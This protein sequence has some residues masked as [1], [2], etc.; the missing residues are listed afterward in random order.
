MNTA[1]HP[2]AASSQPTNPDLEDNEVVA[3]RSP[4]DELLEQLGR[5]QEEMRTQEL[6]DVLGADSGMAA[7]HD[8]I[9]AEQ[10][11][12]N[13]A[14]IAAGEL[15]AP[16][17]DEVLTDGAASVEPMYEPES[18]PVP[19]PLPEQ[20]QNDPLAEYIRM[21][22]GQP[23]F[24][25]KV[26]GQ[27]MLI[28]LEQARRQI[29]IGTAAEIRMQEAATL[30]AQV[31]ERERQ[32]AASE[33]ALA[34]RKEAALAAPIVPETPDLSEEDLLTEAKEIF[35][36]AFTGTE[37][38]AAQKLAKVLIKLKTPAMPAAQPID[39]D[40]IARKA[41]AAAAQVLEGRDKQKDVQ[42][43]YAQFKTDYP[44]IMAD[45][46]LYRM[47]DDMTD[48]I[49]REHPEWDISQVMLEAGKRT[50]AWVNNLKGDE[51]TQ[52]PKS[53][54]KDKVTDSQPQIPPIDRQARKQ[55]LVRIPQGAQ[56]A[57]HETPREDEEKPQ[58]AH[59]AF[60]ELRKARG[61]PV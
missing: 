33:A 19:E 28:P 35:E 5:Q 27:H 24:Q 20:L 52:D 42:K 16:E 1:T 15:P 43:G 57:I 39:E 3:K 2:G 17:P 14:A 59:E 47:A 34:Q 58:T 38:E 4:R 45:P 55:G 48:E 50:R 25:A 21:E 8:A 7:T 31:E 29:Q 6:Q 13:E 54:P 23:M 41:A 9:V 61:Q 60:V 22:Q 37:E 18:E 46:K 12:L 11:E 30:Q 32:V 51:D 40:A 36:T 26:N 56:G 44:D 10:Q 49:E 53:Q